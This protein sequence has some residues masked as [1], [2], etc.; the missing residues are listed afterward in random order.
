MLDASDPLLLDLCPNGVIVRDRL[1]RQLWNVVACNPE[2]GE[3]ITL[4]VLP[5]VAWW[6]RVRWR[7]TRGDRFWQVG[8]SL[9]V[10]GDELA[11]RHG[12]WPAPLTIEPRQWL[13]ITMDRIRGAEG[14]QGGRELTCADIDHLLEQ[15]DS[16]PLP[17]LDDRTHEEICGYGDDGLCDHGDTP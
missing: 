15:V 11:R 12:F 8:G 2:T 6:A 10:V 13:H 16:E 5:V 17:V 1:G 7:V 3:V 14:N 4:A 9:A